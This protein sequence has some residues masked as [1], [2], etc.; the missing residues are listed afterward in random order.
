MT[1]AMRTA[2]LLAFSTMLPRAA[3]A[4]TR[5][6]TGQTGLLAEWDVNATVTQRSEG[7]EWTGPLSLKHVGFCSVDGPEEKIGELRLRVS[8]SSGNATATLLIDGKVCTFSGTFNDG[9][10]G[11]MNCPGQPAAPMMLLVQ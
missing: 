3:D 2:V 7:G 4:Q 1:A 9:Y 11:N 5:T 10:D 6:V 8:A